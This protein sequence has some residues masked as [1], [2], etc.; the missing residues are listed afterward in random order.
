MSRIPTAA[1]AAIALLA[2]AA[3]GGS[4]APGSGDWAGT[5]RDS[6]GIAIVEN[7][8]EGMWT[9]AD[10]W[11]VS[12]EL[13]IGTMDGDA[14]YQFGGISGIAGLATGGVAVLDGQAQDFRIFSPSGE[15]LRTIGR[16]GSGPG[17]FGPGAGPVLVAA[18]DTLLIPDL[19]NERLNRYT[20]DG[21]PLGSVRVSWQQTGLP[22]AWADRPDGTIVTQLRPFALP[23][24][25]GEAGGNDVLVRRGADGLVRDTLMTFE[26]GR[27]VDFSG[28]AERAE[29]TIFAP[30]PVWAP[31]GDRVVF[32][33]NDDFRL[34][35][36]REDGTIERI[37]TM[38]FTIR[39]VTQED[40]DALMAVMVGL[41]EDFGLP[42][43]AIDIAKQRI[44]F[45]DTYP[46]FARVQGGPDGT[47]WVQELRPL[48]EMS[49]GDLS[50]VAQGTVGSP[51]WR[52]FDSEGV[53]L[54]EVEMPDRF[55]PLRFD[56]D[57]I[58][59]VQRDDLDV[60]YAVVLRLNRG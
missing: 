28:G 41:W 1:R 17:E 16:A 20:P 50:T 51:T 52:V 54:G 25:E 39:E 48:T 43:E 34:S 21:E 10:R 5:R 45:A 4:G 18:G 3:C 40:R 55:Q 31:S 46:A 23:G 9:D 42:A 56:G 38:P 47:I 24:A 36:Y 30:E 8:A 6:A 12:E 37:F 26:S 35:V 33:V 2:F 57:R 22:M 58:L 32:G 29:A 44:H 7:P 19:M 49:P 27:T 60:Q 59:G 53:F 14:A 11:T 13:R 15:H